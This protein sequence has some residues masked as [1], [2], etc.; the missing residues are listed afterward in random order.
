MKPKREP[1]EHLTTKSNGLKSAQEVLYQEEF[2]KA[3]RATKGSGNP[4]NGRTK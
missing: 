4:Q 2:R 1:H 3:D